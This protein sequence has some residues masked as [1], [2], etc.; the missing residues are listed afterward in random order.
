MLNLELLTELGRQR[1][2]DVAHDVA[3]CH[4]ARSPRIAV[5]RA[6]VALGALAV[7]VGTALDEESERKPEITVA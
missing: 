2:R 4:H 3:R 6:L 7:C 1:R 5:G